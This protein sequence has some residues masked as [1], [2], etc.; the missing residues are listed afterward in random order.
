MPR[1]N[2]GDVAVNAGEL[3]PTI[4]PS[5]AARGIVRVSRRLAHSSWARLLACV[6]PR[7]SIVEHCLAPGAG[8]A[9]MWPL[10]VA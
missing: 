1:L 3:A 5:L 10:D 7:E 2:A 8:N 4:M 9:P 6:V